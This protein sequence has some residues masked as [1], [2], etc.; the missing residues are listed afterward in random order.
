MLKNIPG[1]KGFLAKD[2][3]PK[4]A[5][6]LIPR[7]NASINLKPNLLKA[8]FESLILI[9]SAMFGANFNLFTRVG[10]PLFLEHWKMVA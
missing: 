5:T 6:N 8:I 10:L 7:W 9:G 1:E 3:G 2:S 4:D